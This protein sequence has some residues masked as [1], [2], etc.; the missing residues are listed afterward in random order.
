MGY[1]CQIRSGSETRSKIWG[2]NARNGRLAF[3]VEG[4]TLWTNWCA[5]DKDGADIRRAMGGRSTCHPNS[6]SI[7]VTDGDGNLYVGTQVGMLQKWGSPTG[8][9]RDIQLLSTLNSNAAFTDSAIAFGPG[10]MVASTCSSMI[11]MET[12][13]S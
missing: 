9:S 13:L 6:M 4:P 12:G 11:V 3:Q 1:N 7:P 8:H 2:L 5:G 10:F